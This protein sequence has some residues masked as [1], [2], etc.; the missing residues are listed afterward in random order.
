LETFDTL[1]AVV[2]SVEFRN[3]PENTKPLV[4]DC[5]AGPKWVADHLS[6]IRIDP[7]KIMAGGSSGGVV[8]SCCYSTLGSR[9]SG[10]QIV[11]TTTA[12]PNA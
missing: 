9:L 10:F 7:K 3:A 6:E 5:F 12:L 2:I 1:N 11:C 8:A 4:K